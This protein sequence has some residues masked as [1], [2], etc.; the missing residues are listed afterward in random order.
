MSAG[1]IPA[2]RSVN[3]H[4]YPRA[5]EV[6]LDHVGIFADDPDAAGAALVRL[7]F[8]LT[9]YRVHT[10]ALRPGEP[11][12]PLG[13]AN[14][15]AMLRVGYVEMLCPVG[16]TPL[17]GQLRRSLARY[18]GL[19]LIAFTGHDADEH[20]AALAAD[21]LDPAPI[22]RIE[23]TQA[24]PEGEVLVRARIVR[25]APEAWPEGRVQAV[26]PQMSADAVWHADLV[27]HANA[28]DRL[29][30]MLVVVDDPAARAA[31]FGAFAR[32]PVRAAGDRHV[33][34][35]DRGRVHFIAPGALTRYVPGRTA[36]ALP[37]MAAVA[38]GS[39]DLAR[40]RACFLERGVAFTAHGGTVQT[41]APDG[42][43]ATFVFHERDDD[44]V[45]DH[46]ATAH[47]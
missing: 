36:P 4:Q 34:E 38:L 8:A 11:V 16:T 13:T 41:A 44:L 2:T 18:P 25:L 23:R 22:A 27:V 28:A 3:P 19:H 46:L 17:S 20:H 40:T 42:L 30:E 33:L 7:G 26:F 1:T 6:F 47:R 24:T 45:F 29:S 14:R 35:T 37:Y 43:G 39:H 15:S 21:G 9:P 10:G 5:G 12:A 32:R 31:R